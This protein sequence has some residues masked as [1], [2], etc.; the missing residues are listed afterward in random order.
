[1][2]KAV[3][4]GS[5]LGVA[6]G[7]EVQVAA[8]CE[9]LRKSATWNVAADLPESGEIHAWLKAH[10][11]EEKVVYEKKVAATAAAV[12]WMEATY[13]KRYIAHTSIE[14]SCTV[15]EMSGGGLRVWSH[16]QGVY[17]L[18]DDLAGVMKLHPGSI[19]VSHVEGSG[20]YGHNGADDVAIDAAVLARAAQGSPVKVQWTCEDESA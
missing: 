4:D 8:A 7:R 17:P 2:I 10:P 1:M 16:T 14:P 6:A 15:A 9:A 12:R 11:S 19:V 20:C 3:R 5:F 18:H 13:T